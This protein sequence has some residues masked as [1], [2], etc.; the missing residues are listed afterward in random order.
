M[1]YVLNMIQKGTCSAIP[2]KPQDPKTPL[3]LKPGWDTWGW[4]AVGRERCPSSKGMKWWV[5]Q[6]FLLLPKLKRHTVEPQEF[7]DFL[8]NGKLMGY[9]WREFSMWIMCIF[10][11]WNEWTEVRNNKHILRYIF[12]LSVQNSR[13]Q[14]L[15]KLGF[16]VFVFRSAKFFR[17]EDR[18]ENEKT[19]PAT[20]SAESCCGNIG[21]PM[22][23]YPPYLDS[24]FGQTK[25]G[26]YHILFFFSLW[27]TATG[28]VFI[29]WN[30][31]LR[32]NGS[33]RF[34]P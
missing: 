29:L 24:Q 30:K 19:H 22:Q 15:G 9:F 32:K 31:E 4:V 33:K 18:A 6:H 1:S 10:T 3:S 34:R 13:T 17:L 16:R 12:I 7:G 26:V 21:W 11:Q 25:V 8:A 20:E 5:G 23:S 27:K 14:H 28:R 2:P